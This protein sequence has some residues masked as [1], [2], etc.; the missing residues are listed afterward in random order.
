MN[1]VSFLFLIYVTVACL[2]YFLFPV[3]FRKFRSCQW[4]VL[5]A[6][7]WMF[8]LLCAGKYFFFLLVTSWTVYLGARLIQKQAD[9]QHQAL[10][11]EKKLGR[12]EK[13]AIRRVFTKRKHRILWAVLLLNFGI[14]AFF[15]YVPDWIRAASDGE[16]QLSLL[17]PIGISF[18]TFQATGYL[19]D[20]CNGNVKA[21]K[22]FWKTA[23]FVS[24]FPQIIQGPIGFWDPVAE[25]LFAEHRPEW[26]RIK[27]GLELILWGYLRKM[28]LADRLV[29]D[30]YLVTDS[31]AQYS[32]SM[33][34][35]AVLLYAIQLY[36]D[37]AGGIDI[38]R[39]IA[40]ILGIDLPENFRQPYLATSINDYWRRWHITLGAWMKKYVFYPLALT[41]LFAGTGKKVAATRFGKTGFGKHAGKVLP[42]ALSCIVVFLIVG[43][44]HGAGGKYV[45]FGLWNGGI[46]F[47]SMMLE[48]FFPAW[49][50]V[51]HIR[52]G[53]AGFRI[54]QI[55]RTFLLVF[56]GYVFDV[57]KDFGAAMEILARMVMHAQW[58]P[59]ALYNEINNTYAEFNTWNVLIVTGMTVLMIVVDRYH[60]RHDPHLGGDGLGL[61]ERID[62][63][64]FWREWLLVLACVCAIVLLGVY[65]P[66]YAPVKFVYAGF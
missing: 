36:A 56:I 1:C 64:C 45:A 57:A 42:A 40:Q 17:V 9:L 11:G 29:K 41:P 43:I 51:L 44:W 62:Q 35:V 22:S 6:A 52:E 14:L 23:L 39:G 8:Y 24:F 20:V 49:K 47:L 13:K 54:F 31:Y 59:H 3:V 32:G 48:P 37:F 50:R 33:A 19:I 5:L 12:E 27:H 26:T 58:N 34:A 2:A 18:Y 66:G 15:K 25:Q 65:G 61:R 63:G 10:S 46:I 30:I 16:K 53:A 4:T 7:S 28:V 21:E 55:L 60:E 38:S